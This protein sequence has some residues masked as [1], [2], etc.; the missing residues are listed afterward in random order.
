MKTWHD[1]AFF[2]VHYDFHAN[3]LD[4]EIGAR[5]TKEHLIDRLSK[6]KPDWIQCDC[7]G[8]AGWTSWFSKVG[9][10]SPGVI[11]DSVRIHREATAELGIK[12]GMHYSGVLDE[13]A[14]ALHPEWSALDA[15]YNPY[16]RGATCRLSGYAK[17]LMIPQMLELV[18]DYDVDGFWVDGENWGS[19]PCWCDRCRGAFMVKT[20]FDTVPQGNGDAHWDEWLAF[21][22]DLFTAYVTEYSEA[23]HAVKPGCAVCSN[24]MYTVRQPEEVVAKVDYLS[25]DY[26]WDWGAE[27]AALEARMLDGRGM[28]WDLMVWGFSI[29]FV[30]S[31][32]SVGVY[33]M[34]NPLHLKQEVSEVLALGG[35]LMVYVNPERNGWL[36]GWQNDIIAEVGE[37]ARERKEFCFQTES[38]S[39]A[40]VLHPVSSYYKSNDPLY[41]YGKSIEPLEGALHALLENHI[42]TDIV[43]DS[44]SAS[45]L[46]RYGL[47]IVPERK[48]LTPDTIGKIERFASDG[49]SVIMSGGH[50]CREHAALCG[51]GFKAEIHNK[52]PG[53]GLMHLAAGTESVGFAGTWCTVKPGDGVA[54]VKHILT[55]RE[56]DEIDPS[57]PVVTKI[58]VGKGSITAVHG[59][60][61]WN[62]YLKHYPNLRRLVGELIDGSGFR[63]SVSVQA[64]PELE[65]VLRKRGTAALINLINRGAVET[66]GPTR[67]MIE[68]LH[69][70]TDTK[71]EIARAAPPR[72][73]VQ[74]PAGD[75]LKWTYNDGILSFE[76]PEV[77]IHEIVEIS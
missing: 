40:A 2:G 61:F 56:P 8:H 30:K 60:I 3:E 27:R 42:S 44:I 10:P 51:A 53:S 54:V 62:Y 18:E 46:S 5:L 33:Q 6:T 9:S 49:G 4:T 45:D 23:I 41:N 48:N 34:K 67:V 24:W 20:G 17:E 69:P 59:P 77:A 25:G 63:Q 28:S 26:T 39:E 12:L 74:R 47:L 35:A 38:A 37:F 32:A 29:V 7:K 11:N 15:D 22:R 36:V 19:R 68:D 72:Q 31:Q 14:V 43:T 21:H 57:K 16:P 70:V 1:D 73:V 58:S 13:R 55:S 50:L 71:V 52:G 65:L 75:Q 76:V 66:L 64:G